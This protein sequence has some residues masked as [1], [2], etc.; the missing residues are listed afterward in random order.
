MSTLDLAKR[1][2]SDPSTRIHL[3]D[4]VMAEVRR[5]RQKMG[6][7]DFATMGDAS[8]DA[9]IRRVGAYGEVMKDLLRIGV[10]LGRW[11]G[12]DQQSLI[13]QTLD[14][15]A[16][17]A[18]IQNGNRLWLSLRVYPLMLMQYAIGIGGIGRR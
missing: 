16:N 7:D 5:V 3:H 13:A 14:L 10:L 15:L 8:N 6:T 18:D 1:Y 11:G 12:V 9:F 4:L 17:H 2:L